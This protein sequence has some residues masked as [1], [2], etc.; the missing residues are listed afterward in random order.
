MKGKYIAAAEQ[1]ISNST[2][3]NTSKNE[4]TIKIN[5]SIKDNKELEKHSERRKSSI[6]DNKGRPQRL[7]SRYS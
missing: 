1:S 6:E 5:S 3:K 2:Y 4:D 7:K